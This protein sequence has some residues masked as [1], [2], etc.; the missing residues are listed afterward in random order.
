MYFEKQT[1]LHVFDEYVQGAYG[2]DKLRREQEIA[3]QG[4][5]SKRLSKHPGHSVVLCA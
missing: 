3:P 2:S 1:A 5:N 4:S